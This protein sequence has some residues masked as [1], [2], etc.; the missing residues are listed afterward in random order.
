MS[1]NGEAIDMWVGINNTIIIHGRNLIFNGKHYLLP[2][3]KPEAW[4]IENK[5][6]VDN[7][8]ILSSTPIPESLSILLNKDK[9]EF[10]WIQGGVTFEVE[11]GYNSCSSSELS[12]NRWD[13]IIG[14]MYISF[15]DDIMS[16][17]GKEYGSVVQGDLVKIS[18][19]RKI[20]VI[21]GGGKK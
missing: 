7:I 8:G 14:D 21:K 11:Y 13:A 5:V 9:H 16:I 19:N 15:L 4:I 3:G 17:E 2:N 18:K 20:V 12:K 10:S 6:Y 1:I